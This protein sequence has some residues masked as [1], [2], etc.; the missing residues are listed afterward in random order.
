MILLSMVCFASAESSADSSDWATI[1]EEDEWRS[2]HEKVKLDKT[3]VKVEDV[4]VASC[5]DDGKVQLWQPLQVENYIFPL[6]E[7]P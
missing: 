2:R 1:I 4:V 3:K 5:C 7:V 6:T